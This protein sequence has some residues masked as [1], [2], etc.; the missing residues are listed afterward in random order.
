MRSG[1]L[2]NMIVV[3]PNAG[4][5]G[6]RHDSWGAPQGQA[7]ILGMYD[8]ETSQQE[9][10]SQSDTSDS[11]MSPV[12]LKICDFVQFCNFLNSMTAM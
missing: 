12:Q 6:G 1:Q 5:V 11:L 8:V 3:G 9:S 4:I 2:Y 10:K 7:N